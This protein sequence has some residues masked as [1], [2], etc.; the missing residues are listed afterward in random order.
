MVNKITQSNVSIDVKSTLHVTLISMLA[1]LTS[2]SEKVFDPSRGQDEY[3]KL[4]TF[5]H[6]SEAQKRER[7]KV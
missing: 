1:D 3:L 4:L 6:K 7:D 5:N 2:L